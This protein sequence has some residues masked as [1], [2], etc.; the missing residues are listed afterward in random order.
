MEVMF[1]NLAQ[2]HV[3]G[4]HGTPEYDSTGTVYFINGIT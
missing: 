4:I 2:F 1:D 3:A